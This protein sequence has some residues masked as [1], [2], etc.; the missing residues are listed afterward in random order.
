MSL[1]NPQNIEKHTGPGGGEEG[2]VTQKYLK[3]RVFG[4]DQKH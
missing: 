4:S 1:T 3:T 2:G